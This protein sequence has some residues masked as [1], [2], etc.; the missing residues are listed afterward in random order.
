MAM[1]FDISN[2]KTSF[3]VIFDDGFAK[4][5]FKVTMED[6]GERAFLVD[7]AD[8]DMG[9]YKQAFIEAFNDDNWVDTMKESVFGSKG[10]ELGLSIMNAR[11]DF[12]QLTG[13][14]KR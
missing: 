7:F 13:R 2:K 12:L 8:I 3:P 14:A 5:T 11:A 6:K 9:E 10:I 4:G 1:K